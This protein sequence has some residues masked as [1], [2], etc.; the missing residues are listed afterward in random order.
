MRRSQEQEKRVARIVG[1][2]VNPGSG[3][4]WNRPNDVREP[5][6]V[7]YEMKRTDAKSIT[8]K[9]SDLEAVRKRALLDDTDAVMHLEFGKRRYV[10]ITE[11]DY[12]ALRGD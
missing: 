2:V 12:L 8:V 7:L 5:G 10:V 1:G 6:K 4:R 3:S 11:D 9:L